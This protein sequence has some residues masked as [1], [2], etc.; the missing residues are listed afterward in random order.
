MYLLEVTRCCYNVDIAI[1]IAMQ[2]CCST[3]VWC[4]ECCEC[5][6]TLKGWGVPKISACL[7]WNQGAFISRKLHSKDV[8][9]INRFQK[10][11]L[12]KVGITSIMIF[13]NNWNVMVLIQMLNYLFLQPT[14]LLVM[15]HPS[16]FAIIL[17]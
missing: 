16:K 14:L 17:F 11:L 1:D 5:C 2:C 6:C 7:E 13:L 3:Q 10:K 12:F 15:T 4:C 9:D 8:I